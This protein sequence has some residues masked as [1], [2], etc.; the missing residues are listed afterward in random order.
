M[1]EKK[2]T[3]TEEQIV[4]ERFALN[5]ASNNDT[6]TLTPNY[7][8]VNGEGSDGDTDGS[9]SDGDDARF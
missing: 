1:E 2:F 3:L 9:E 7:E 5:N 8:A 4:V 6:K